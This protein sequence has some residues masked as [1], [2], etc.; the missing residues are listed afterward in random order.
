MNPSYA[1]PQKLLKFNIG[2]DKKF[3]KFIVGDYWDDQTI[4]EI[5]SLLK[6]YKDLFLQSFNDLKWF[7][8]DLGGMGTTLKPNSN[9]VSIILIGSTLTLRKRLKTRSTTS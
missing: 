3:K 9:Q 8:N 2:I 6:E 4:F 1:Q 5:V 7:P